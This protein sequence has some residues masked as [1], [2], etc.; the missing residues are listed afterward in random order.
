MEL[1][2]HAKGKLLKANLKVIKEQYMAGIST[3]ELALRFGVGKSVIH[4]LLKKAGVPMRGKPAKLAETKGMMLV[5]VTALNKVRLHAFAHDLSLTDSAS[6]LISAGYNV[7]NPELPQNGNA[8]PCTTQHSE[9]FVLEGI[10]REAQL[11]PSN[12]SLKQQLKDYEER[13]D[14]MLFKAPSNDSLRGKD[15]KTLLR[16]DLPIE[17]DPLKSKRDEWIRGMNDC[18]WPSRDEES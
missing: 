12:D 17:D 9:L 5:R 2:N 11:N 18:K 13:K 4:K 15:G 3:R 6:A 1:T 16:D 14:S 7:L 10:H 8:A